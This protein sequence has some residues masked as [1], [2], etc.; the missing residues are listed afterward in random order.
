[1][2]S[3]HIDENDKIFQTFQVNEIDK[4]KNNFLYPLVVFFSLNFVKIENLA[5]FST[6]FLD[7]HSLIFLPKNFQT[8]LSPLYENSL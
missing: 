2:I 3:Y 5:E 7:L 8:F 1:M 4:M 6:M